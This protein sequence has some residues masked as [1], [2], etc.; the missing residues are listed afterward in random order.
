MSLRR[1]AKYK[2]SLL[3]LSAEDLVSEAIERMVGDNA[4]AVLL[5]ND[6][7]AL[8]GIFTDRDVLA[9]IVLPK[10]DPDT[11]PLGK[12]MTQDVVTLKEDSSLDVAIHC[13]Q[14]HQ[15]SHLPI[16]GTEQ[17]IIGMM[18]IRHLLHD[19]VGDLVG[20]LNRLEAYLNDAPGG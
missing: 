2:D 10:V 1:F 12:V 16:L 7:G 6:S 8:E 18:T 9:R 17:E 3:L 13:M 20:E 4:A 5:V 11:T 15:I 19:K 14:T